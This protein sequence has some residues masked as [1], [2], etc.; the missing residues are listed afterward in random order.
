MP[1]KNIDFNSLAYLNL[2][3]END[4]EIFLS[5][6]DGNLKIL[7]QR[8]QGQALLD[9]DVSIEGLIEFVKKNLISLI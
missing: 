4:I 3:D 9:K 2:A 6:I 8:F 1:G 7:K 5:Y